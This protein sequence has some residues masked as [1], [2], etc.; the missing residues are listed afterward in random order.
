MNDGHALWQMG[1]NPQSEERFRQAEKLILS[2]PAERRN[3]ISLGQIYANWSG[4]LF[5]SSRFDQAIAQV[6]LGLAVLEPRV[7]LEPNDALAR[8]TCLQL[9]GNRGLA[10][11]A[12]GKHRESVQEW[13]RVIALA[14]KPVPMS[15]HAG[16]AVELAQVGELARALAEARIVSSATGIS[17]ADC[18]NLGCLYGLCAVRARNT[19][20]LPAEQRAHEVETHIREALRWLKA[21][22]GAGAFKDSALRAH[23]KNDPDLAIL[24][25]R[26]EFRQI[27][28]PPQ[29]KR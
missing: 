22:Q 20:N 14:P 25:D 13:E 29:S 24:K 8:D 2:I 12:L 28:E 11:S 15:Y 3:V 27:I 6:N 23:A 17:A 18:Y 10:L 21:A 26:P 7:E 9:H 16:L 4:M 5:H 19:T 1:Q